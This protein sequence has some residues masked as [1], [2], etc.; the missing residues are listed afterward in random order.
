MLKNDVLLYGDLR[1][2]ENK[3]KFILEATLS[4]IKTTERFSGSIFDQKLFVKKYPLIT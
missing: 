3:N 4:Y 2:D 1:L